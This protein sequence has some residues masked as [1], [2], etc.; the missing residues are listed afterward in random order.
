MGLGLGLWRCPHAR[1]SLIPAVHFSSTT[2]S[3]FNTRLTSESFGA[4]SSVQ[5][6]FARRTRLILSDDHSFLTEGSQFYSLEHSTHRIADSK[7]RSRS[8]C[9][10]KRVGA[11]SHSPGIH[12]SEAAQ[13]TGEDLQTRKSAEQ[14][15]KQSTRR[16]H[17][18]FI[19]TM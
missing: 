7:P 2:M 12:N 8:T 15:Y 9:G 3:F 5:G 16:A 10:I 4:T 6:V 13:D 18:E 14:V 1:S 19:F 17:G 11:N